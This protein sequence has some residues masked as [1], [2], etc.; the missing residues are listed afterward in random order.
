[1][2]VERKRQILELLEQAL[3]RPAADREDF[4][5]E[6][7]DDDSVRQEVEN[8]L[9]TESGGGILAEPAFDVHGSDRNVGR[10]IDDYELI[11][12]LDRGG[13]GAVYLAERHDFEH[14]VALKLI[15]RGLDLDEVLVRRFENERQILAR[16]NHPA[17]ARLLDGGTT[18]DRLPYFVME[19]VDG[20]P[21]HRYCRDR[22]LSVEQRLELFREVCSAVQFAHKNL[23]IHRDLKP[24]NILVTADGK[25][26]LLDFGIAKLLDEGLAAQAVATE[27]GQGPMTPRYASPE[28][29]RLEPVTTASDIYSLGVLLYQ[30]LTGLDP[31]DLDTDR[32]DEI[33]RAVLEQDPDRPSTAVRRRAADQVGDSDALPDPRKL[34]R[35]L[36]G[37]LDSIVLK[38]IRKEPD[39]RYQSVDQLSE[40]I[41]RHLTGLPVDARVGSFSYTAGKFI[42]R[43][44][45]ALVVAASLAVA[46]IVAFVLWQEIARERRRSQTTVD[47]LMEVVKRAD[48]DLA[49]EDLEFFEDSEVAKGQIPGDVDDKT[50][51]S[52]RLSLSD[53]LAK[54]FRDLAAY[55]KSVRFGELSLR[56]AE[57]LHGRKHPETAKR[58]SNLAVSYYAL[59]DYEKA[60]KLFRESLSIREGFGQEGQDLFR[61]KSNLGS[62]LRR[63]RS[64]EE[65]E[66]L[67][68]EVL[69]GREA[70]YL[71]EY[72]PHDKDV[73]RS[74]HNLGELYYDWKRFE[75]AED[76]LRRALESRRLAYKPD[77]TPVALTADLLGRVLA[78]R[79][80]TGEA[81][82]LLGQ[83]LRIRLQRLGEAHPDTVSTREYLEQLKSRDEVAD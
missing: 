2:S 49:I 73:A 67:L 78:S 17:I 24:G 70:L 51:W 66:R 48:P 46:V 58:L 4:L 28:Q 47:Y 80:L 29:I 50:I 19:Y 40:D 74:R 83:A 54:L 82:D 55:E 31:Y 77:T 32:S 15:R 72:G 38:A 7:C 81:E 75:V 14:Q 20:E 22:G 27:L 10:H 37:D 1:M 6:A 63:K 3:E 52:T 65:A 13:M 69:K 16:L 9:E 59:E 11:R 25:P 26:K 44:W 18:G 53:S 60:E 21:I 45:L 61:I 41:R 5:N 64:F 42:R 56:H 30:L 34:Q 33:A 76:Y 71:E 79:G 35:R 36:S 57:K 23:V 68:L 62:V 39:R 12:L 43:H 8:L